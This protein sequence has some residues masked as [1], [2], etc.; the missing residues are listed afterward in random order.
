M[1]P[2]IPFQIKTTMRVGDTMRQETRNATTL[3]QAVEIAEKEL[4]KPTS[5]R[6]ETWVCLNSA[7]RR[8][9]ADG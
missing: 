5:R 7:D 9:G 8:G 2:S 1:I 6:V 3:P 4:R